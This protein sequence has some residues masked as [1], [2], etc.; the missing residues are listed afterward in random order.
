MPNP[1][2]TLRFERTLLLEYKSKPMRLDYKVLCLRPV[3]LCC[4]QTNKI[5]N[6]PD[7]V[8]SFTLTVRLH[9]FPGARML[10]LHY[11]GRV[12]RALIVRRGGHRAAL[13][14]NARR[15]LL[16]LFRPY[17]PCPIYVRVS[18]VRRISDAN[19]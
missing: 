8:Q 5:L 14:P 2:T 13:M 4:V 12:T 9:K 10:R 15:L 18:N 6:L 3:Y 17:I 7:D 1:G 11:V 16:S 19:A